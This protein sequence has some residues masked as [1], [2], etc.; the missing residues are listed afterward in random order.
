MLCRHA[1]P[2]P[3]NE[4]LDR[5]SKIPALAPFALGGGTS[6]ALRFAHR[7]SVD[8]DFFTLQEFSPET[9]ARDLGLAEARIVNQAANSLVLDVSS[10][11]VDFLR[12]HYE[13]LAPVEVCEGFR[14]L[15][16]PDVVAMK[17]NAIVNRGSKKD[18]FDVAELL[19]HFGIKQLLDWFERKYPKSDRFIAIRSLAWFGDAESDPDPVSLKNLGWAEVKRRIARSI[20]NI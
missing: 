4:W 2:N 8:L 20:A 1:I 16:V 7:R 9:L 11:K 12:H 17:L 10:V 6:L 13:L 5:L 19:E 15:S 3:V 14:L 18:F